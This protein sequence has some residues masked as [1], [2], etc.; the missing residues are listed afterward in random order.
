MGTGRH[1]RSF[2]YN[3]E[4]K[5]KEDLY[6]NDGKSNDVWATKMNGRYVVASVLS[7]K[8]FVSS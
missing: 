8:L 4:A 3:L 1:I 7:D 2:W 6:S 5:K